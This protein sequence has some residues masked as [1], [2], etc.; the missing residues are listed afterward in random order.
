MN[1]LI[2]ILKE[3]L[4]LKIIFLFFNLITI[5][6]VHKKSEL[7]KTLK[8]QDSIVFER[9]FNKCEVEK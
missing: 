5:A 9:A 6:Q 1:L 3:F 8:S 2:T 4:N 7:Y